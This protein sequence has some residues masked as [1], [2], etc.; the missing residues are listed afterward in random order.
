MQKDL[1]V[2]LSCLKNRKLK[3]MASA[4]KVDL[5]KPMGA[6]DQE[7]QFNYLVFYKE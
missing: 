7:S 3:Q 1:N 6:L 5:E 2:W 4:R